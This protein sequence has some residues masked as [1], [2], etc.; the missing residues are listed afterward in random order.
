MKTTKIEMCHQHIKNWKNEYKN[1]NMIQQ[2]DHNNV[3]I[4][5]D[6]RGIF[7]VEPPH[8]STTCTS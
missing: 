6:A 1:L 8:A 7:S 4:H 3:Y 5:F 2:C